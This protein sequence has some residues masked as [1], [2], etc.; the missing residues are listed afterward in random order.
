LATL[1]KYKRILQAG[2]KKHS[3]EDVQKIT[4]LLVHLAQIVN[5]TKLIN[6]EK[7]GE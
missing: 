2:G 1:K 3:D 6:D 5:D 4:D 7:L